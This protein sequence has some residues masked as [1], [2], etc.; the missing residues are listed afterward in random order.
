MIFTWI[1]LLGL[2]PR[3]GGAPSPPETTEGLLTQLEQ[4]YASVR[5]ARFTARHNR[6][7]NFSQTWHDRRIAELREKLA[8][9]GN[10]DEAQQALL[11]ETSEALRRS[12]SQILYQQAAVGGPDRFILRESAE[13]LPGD[14][15][16]GVLRNPHESAEITSWHQG[17]AVILNSS[18]DL[19]P[20]ASISDQ[21]PL[22]ASPRYFQPLNELGWNVLHFLQDAQTNGRAVEIQAVEN[23][24]WEVKIAYRQNGMRIRLLLDPESDLRP[25]LQEFHDPAGLVK[26]VEAEYDQQGGVAVPRWLL[27][28]NYEAG[29]P[30]PYQSTRVTI[31]NIEVNQSLTDEMFEVEIPPGS[32]V[33]N[34]LIP[35]TYL[36]GQFEA[37][38]RNHDAGVLQSAVE[39]ADE[40]ITSPEFEDMKAESAVSEPAVS[41]GL[42]DVDE[43]SKVKTT[44]DKG[45][46]FI[47]L[48]IISMLALGI[49]GGY[50]WW[51]SRPTAT[52]PN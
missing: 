5:T 29:Q 32:T 9:D 49:A 20:G 44:S 13:A 45:S 48:G 37:T 31:E 2:S 17:K 30:E 51:R 33:Q 7:I 21:P 8:P 15:K 27:I 42:A 6:Q 14:A 16:L 35:G 41:P 11:D 4:A 18:E 1:L 47:V 38:F 22:K 52:Q 36:Q 40:L 34:S 24:L 19:A 28:N 26:R 12:G 23:E 39:L 50:W 46:P 43:E 3:A 25:V 10:L